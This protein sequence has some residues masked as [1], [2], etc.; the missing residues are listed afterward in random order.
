MRNE[1]EKARKLEEHN[2]KLKEQIEEL[3]QQRKEIERIKQAEVDDLKKELELLRSQVM[4]MSASTLSNNNG[5]PSF[6]G[7]TPTISFN[8]AS[9]EKLAERKGV[10]ERQSGNIFDQ[11]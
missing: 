1:A 11:I 10:E 6:M 8:E 9:V 4:S 2:Q 3:D 7:L 5:S